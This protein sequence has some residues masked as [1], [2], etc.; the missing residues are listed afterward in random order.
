MDGAES[1]FS[2]RALSFPA[3]SEQTPS[4]LGAASSTAS[5]QGRIGAVEFGYNTVRGAHMR[6]GEALG[7]RMATEFNVLDSVHA[8]IA[9]WRVS[10]HARPAGV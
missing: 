4:E 8:K 7:A 1:S 10:V 3:M 6:F 2:H 9:P 5:G